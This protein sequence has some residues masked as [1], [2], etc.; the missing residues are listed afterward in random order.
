M[1]WVC[2]ECCGHRKRKLPSPDEDSGLDD[3]LGQ[4]DD[5]MQQQIQ[6]GLVVRTADP[7]LLGVDGMQ[8]TMLSCDALRVYL[9]AMLANYQE[10]GDAWR[11][12]WVTSEEVGYKLRDQIH[13][14]AECLACLTSKQGRAQRNYLPNKRRC[15]APNR[16]RG[17]ARNGSSAK[18]STARG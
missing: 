8:D 17:L 5:D 4:V 14:G 13:R 10:R 6:M 2:Y 9:E 1:T 12:D 11:E 7:T 16:Q 15:F 18:A 3:H